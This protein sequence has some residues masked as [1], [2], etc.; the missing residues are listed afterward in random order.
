MPHS[1]VVSFVSRGDGWYAKPRT[2]AAKV[3]ERFTGASGDGDVVDSVAP[4]ARGLGSGRDQPFAADGGGEKLDAGTGS[5]HG[6]AVRI[7]GEGERGVGQCENDASMACAMTVQHVLPHRHRQPYAPGLNLHNLDAERSSGEI[8]VV[9]A[10]H[11]T[12]GTA[13]GGLER[14]LARRPGNV[15]D[16]PL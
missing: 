1:S 7:A 3:R 8:P 2:T 4:A 15:A 9:Q 10:L 5:H 6:L 12:A 16:V 11:G 13:G 14:V